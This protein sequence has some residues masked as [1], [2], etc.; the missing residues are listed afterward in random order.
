MSEYHL[1][2]TA[3]SFTTVVEGDFDEMFDRIEEHQ[4]DYGADPMDHFVEF[5]RN[6]AE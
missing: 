5:E 4:A 3:C 2:C 6:G 1:T